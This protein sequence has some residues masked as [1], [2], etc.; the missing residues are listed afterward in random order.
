MS[1][2][3]LRPI[4]RLMA[5]GLLFPALVLGTMGCDVDDPVDPVDPNENAVPAPVDE[6][7]I[8]EDPLDDEDY[9][10]E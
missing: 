3:K 6:D 9:M 7:P 5:A 2:E 4:L 8:D 10:D 1:T